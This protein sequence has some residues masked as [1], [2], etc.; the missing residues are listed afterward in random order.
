MRR[1]SLFPVTSLVVLVAMACP[2][3]A[4]QRAPIRSAD[5]ARAD[6]QRVVSTWVERANAGD[7]AGVASFYTDDAVFLD[8]YGNVVRGRAAIEQMFAQF[9]ADGSSNWNVRIDE[10]VML[11]DVAVSTGT[12]SANFLGTPG[13]W[14]WLS[15]WVYEPDGSMRSR[16]H[17]G[18]MPA[19]R[20]EG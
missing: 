4:Q 20:Q 9:S 7:A 3:S 12:W 13:P 16:F 19:P 17:L 18:M 10:T 15:V 8:P 5:Q 2:L 14:R 1:V 11:G 6:V